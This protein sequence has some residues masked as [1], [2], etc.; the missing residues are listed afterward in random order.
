VLRE[1]SLSELL[2]PEMSEPLVRVEAATEIPE[3]TTGGEGRAGWTLG[4]M[5]SLFESTKQE[6]EEKT[7][8]P[9]CIGGWIDIARK[10]STP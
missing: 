7:E 1:R 8:V 5:G 6:Q 3:L 10:R 9:T 2:T 4:S